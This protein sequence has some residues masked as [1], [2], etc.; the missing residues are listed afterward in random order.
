MGLQ[1]FF[2]ISSA[3]LYTCSSVSIFCLFLA[4]LLSTAFLSH[5]WTYVPS[6]A[7]FPAYSDAPAAPA[8]SRTATHQ[9]PLDAAALLGALTKP[10]TQ[11]RGS[12]QQP[13]MQ[14][15]EGMFLLAIAG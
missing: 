6:P 4:E 9:L 5:P 1:V 8:C 7:S 13:Y 11:S 12:K 10:K 15:A 2:T 14:E 3:L